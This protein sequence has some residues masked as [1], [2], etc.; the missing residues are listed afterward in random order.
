MAKSILKVDRLNKD[1]QV[2]SQNKLFSKPT[3][4]R[5]LS[6]VSFE[7]M[8][9]ET[10]SIVGESGCG[11]TTLGRCIVRGMDATSGSVY[12][13]PETGEQVDFL[14][15]RGKEFKKYR[16]DIQMIFQDPFSSLSPRMSVYDIIAEPLLANFKLSKSELDEKITQI[17]QQTGLNA[18]YLDRYPHAFSGGQR[19]RIAIAR[20]L[21]SQPRLIVCDEA[22]SALDVSI[23]AQIINLLK[24]LQE[25]LQITYIFISH[26]LSI[27]QNISDRVAVMHL[28]KIVELAPVDALFDDPLHPYTEALLSAVPEPD[29][30]VKKERIILE[31]EVPN[32]AN[33]PSGC[34]FH[35]RCRY[36]TDKCMRE[37]PELQAITEE[38][39]A[40][41]HYASQ[42]V[43]RGVTH[44][45]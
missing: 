12:Y 20:S 8:E 31:G 7:L 3:S 34:H 16:K 18:S 44:E 33:P 13:H 26:D 10:L 32:P 42:L 23:K 40:A 29:P 45:S 22:V 9:G 11:K 36:K 35:P 2:K 17:A 19:Q 6:N 37:E 30:N 38:H 27:V 1:F 14:G 4:V 39:Y 15:L 5:V 24:D 21:I 25:Q 28:G 43:L 41:C